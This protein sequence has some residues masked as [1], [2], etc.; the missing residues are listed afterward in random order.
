MSFGFNQIWPHIGTTLALHRVG[1][2]P[3]SEPIHDGLLHFYMSVTRPQLIQKSGATLLI[4]FNPLKVSKLSTTCKQ[5]LHHKGL[6]L[7]QL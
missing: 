3:L 2:K 6:T 1:D 4:D 7:Y 5:P